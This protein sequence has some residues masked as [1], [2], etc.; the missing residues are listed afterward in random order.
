MAHHPI[1]RRAV[2]VGAG[3]GGLA[4]AM[5]LASQGYEV[6]VLEKNDRV[7]GRSSRITLGEYH[8]DRGATFLMMPHLLEELF[9]AAGRSLGDYVVMKK[10]SPLYALHFGD[11]VFTPSADPEATAACIAELFPGE[12]AGYRRFMKEEEIKF[13]RVMPL[14]QRPFTSLRDYFKADIFKALPR[15]HL[16]ETVYDRLSR[17]FRDERLKLSFTFQAKYLGMSPWDCPGTFTILS[18]LEHRYGLFHP[19]GGINQ[20]F[21]AMAGIIREYGGKIRL[22]TGVKRVITRNGRAEGVL[23]DSGETI[24]A[25][26]VV[27]NADFAAA[28]NR[29]FEPGELKKYTPDKLSRK[30]YSLSTCMMYLGVDGEIQLPHHS[31]YFA[32]DYRRNVEDITRRKQLSDDFSLYIHNPSVLD[33]TLAPPGK[34]S[35][36]VLVPVPNLTGDTDW[37]KEGPAYRESVLE[38]LERIPQLAGIRERIEQELFFTPQDWEEQLHVYQGATFNLAHSL[39]Q[40]MLLRPHN[41]F[42][43]ADGV[44]LVG[45]GTHPGSGLPTIFESAKISVSMLMQQDEELKM[46]GT[47]TPALSGKGSAL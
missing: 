14:L 39:N 42:E 29:L 28:M 37:S 25:D 32:D 2:V 38:R 12:E 36:Y 33:S 19:I 18:Y 6:E 22:S 10:L 8:F 41:K 17:Y 9:T 30:S 24:Q 15:L 44:W 43:E 35:L 11:T 47:R 1:A 3:P 23:L 40:M 5:L 16:T 7:G 21:E 20:V 4:A 45:G 46:A 34:S 27:L 31:V 13:G 26:H